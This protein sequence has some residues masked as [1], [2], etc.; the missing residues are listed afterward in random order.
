MVARKAKSKSGSAASNG[1]APGIKSP[2]GFLNFRHRLGKDPYGTLEDL[3]A[4]FGDTVQVSAGAGQPLVFLF[5]R[6]ANSFIL[7][8][9][10]ELFRFRE[11]YQ[12]L[13][14]VVGETA[15]I[16]SDG[17]DHERLH[18]LVLPAFRPDALAGY[19]ELMV[20]EVQRVID[21]LPVGSVVDL[22]E[23]FRAGIRRSTVGTLFGE[24]LSDRAEEIGHTI[25]PALE[26]ANLAPNKQ[27][28][29]KVVGSNY[30]NATKARIMVD[31]IIDA[32][33]DR[34]LALPA[35]QRPVN[36]VMAVLLAGNEGLTM[37]QL[38]LRDQIVGLL[39]GGYGTTS[40][41]LGWILQELLGSSE[42]WDEA[43][44]EIQ[45][46]VGSRELTMDDLSNL[47][48]L[49][50][51]ISETLRLHP[52][53]VVLPRYVV[54]DFEFD[55]YQ[56]KAGSLV[57]Y[58]PFVTARDPQ[59]WLRPDEFVPQR[60]DSSA[61]GYVPPA[62]YAFVPGGGGSRRCLGFSFATME[63]KVCLVQIIRR[64]TLVADYEGPRKTEGIATVRPAGG[65]PALVAAVSP[66]FSA[67]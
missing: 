37:T 50:G 17:A 25:E 62:S 48:Y 5:G 2:I 66:M 40:A 65:I 22:Q 58:S 52:P 12:S 24:H 41:A 8:Q 15:L 26:F 18:R 28:K 11:A 59:L 67:D 64:L 29:V 16:V 57:F 45:L 61:I 43:A 51:V 56:I 49:D 39:A 30:Y 33:V 10:K 21:E 7:S 36:D 47:F 14:P 60:W 38:E 42:V 27:I 53:S 31:R 19:L 35:D 55:G 44:K 9:H 20:R 3:H 13:I 6:E 46:V 23:R 34:R 54:T 32:E 1:Q 63:L 4:K